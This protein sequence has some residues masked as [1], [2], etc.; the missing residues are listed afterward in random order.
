MKGLYGTAAFLIFLRPRS[1]LRSLGR[2]GKLRG[3]G[4]YVPLVAA[5]QRRLGGLTVIA[6]AIA[7][8]GGRS[9]RLVKFTSRQVVC[10]IDGANELISGEEHQVVAKCSCR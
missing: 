2:T 3:P 6:E 1:R 10:E 7:R 5:D 4:S 9:V 8:D